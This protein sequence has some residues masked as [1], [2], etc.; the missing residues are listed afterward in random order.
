MVLHRHKLP[1]AP[2]SKVVRWG[3]FRKGYGK[4][5]GSWSIISWI[6]PKISRAGTAVVKRVLRFTRSFE[7]RKESNWLKKFWGRPYWQ[8]NSGCKQNYLERWRCTFRS[9]GAYVPCM[10][11]Q[12]G[13]RPLQ[14]PGSARIW[15]RI[16][17]NTGP[18]L[19]LLGCWLDDVRVVIHFIIQRK[20]LKSETTVVLEAKF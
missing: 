11:C 13:G 1:N 18:I 5:Y 3:M 2:T 17:A 8:C 10:C 9:L 19:P 14:F 4:G 7:V 15:S 12:K 6:R 16:A 20:F